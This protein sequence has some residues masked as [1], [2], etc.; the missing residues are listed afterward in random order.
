MFT[1]LRLS[2]VSAFA[3]ALLTACASG[4]G[5]SGGNA[6]S[7]RQAQGDQGGGSGN[8][9]VTAQQAPPVKVIWEAL[10]R[11]RYIY[12]NPNLTA[13]RRVGTVTPD[14][15]IVLVNE[16]HPE[17][18]A[19]RS[20]KARYKDAGT[21][22]LSNRDM[23]NLMDGLTQIGYFRTARST[24]ST[25]QLFDNDSSR[26]RVTVER[27]SGSVTVLS[28]RGQGL[29]PNTKHIP[30]IYSQAKQA[31]AMLK[32]STPTLRVEAIGTSPVPY[33]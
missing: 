30:G 9:A 14:L 10:A 21:G 3:V 29:D 15:K 16:A 12:E 4:G 33:R 1:I 24:G 2:L 7:S 25:S 26:G 11:E 18:E 5:G 27:A 13:R 17:A 6:S 28:M 20:G 32:N 31:V 22:V 23:K 19:I 8:N